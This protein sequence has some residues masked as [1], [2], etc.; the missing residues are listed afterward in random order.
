MSGEKERTI[1]M[2][3]PPVAEIH[4]EFV[5]DPIKQYFG[6]ENTKRGRIS[7]HELV[8]KGLASDTADED[9][10]YFVENPDKVP[11]D[12]DWILF[13]G[14]DRVWYV[15]R[16][17]GG[18]YRDGYSLDLAWDDDHLVARRRK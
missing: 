10:R 8:A 15:Y 4:R 18:L 3:V 5:L 17:E 14:K 7:G 16:G 11:A 6:P 9:S 2:D 12:A 13:V 1:V